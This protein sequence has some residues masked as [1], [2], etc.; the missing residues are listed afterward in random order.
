MGILRPIKTGVKQFLRRNG[1]SL[2]RT[3]E[4]TR[5]ADEYG[6]DKGTR[7]SSHGYTRVYSRLFERIRRDEIILLEMGLLRTDMDGRRPGNAAEGATEAACSRA[8]SLEMWHAFFPMARIYGFDID[9]FSSVV[10]DRC[11]TVSGD[12]SS[13]VDLDR[14]VQ[15]IG[16]PIDIV[17]D[18]AS[19]ASHHQQI[20]LGHLFP[21]VRPG[22]MYI[23]EDLHWQD[24]ALEG[25]GAPKTRDIL[26]RLQAVGIF[27]SPFL[28]EQQCRYIVENL[29]ALRLYDSSTRDV[30]DGTDALAILMKRQA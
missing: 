23:I 15:A 30:D 5:L 17:I 16:K 14:L 26:R 10:M 19:H 27:R 12:M 25:K 4:L 9:D 2:N 24:P 21:C 6:S 28:T 1:L 20:A 18:D 7:L 22:G 3:D 13:A 29:G 11:T 8:P